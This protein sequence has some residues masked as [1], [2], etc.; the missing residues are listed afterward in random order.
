MHPAGFSHIS[1]LSP[2]I[3][4]KSDILHDAY[5]GGAQDGKTAMTDSLERI[6]GGTITTAKGFRAGGVYCGV[7]P[8]GADKLDLGLLYSEVR[9]AAA[10]VFTKNKVTAPAILVDRD[11]LKEPYAQAVVVNSGI[12]NVSVGEQG[13]VDAEEMS[14]L[15]GNKLGVAA[16]DVLV[17]STGRY[18][19]GASDGSDPGRD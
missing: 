2:E 5:A 10:A 11:Y 19:G 18:R 1:G 7:K 13:R 17:A 12:A 9:A 3:K 16:E 14:E 6:E 15:A 4:G 8:Y